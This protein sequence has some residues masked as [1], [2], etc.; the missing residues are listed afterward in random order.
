VSPSE[1]A[2][3]ARL[4]ARVTELATRFLETID[5]GDL[6]IS[7]TARLHLIELRIAVKAS[8]ALAEVTAEGDGS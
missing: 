4:D 1:K 8:Q 7:A 2:A 3:Q 5:R 6:N